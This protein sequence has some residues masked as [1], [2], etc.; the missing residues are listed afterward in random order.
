MN[1]QLTIQKCGNSKYRFG[2]NTNDSKTIFGKRGISIK[3][4][5][6]N[7]SSDFIETKTKCGPSNDNFTSK[8]RKKGYDLYDIKINNWIKENNYNIYDPGK[9]TKLLFKYNKIKKELIFIKKIDKT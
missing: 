1:L 6:T 5:W 7:N 9:P 4:F 3:I 8:I 2:I